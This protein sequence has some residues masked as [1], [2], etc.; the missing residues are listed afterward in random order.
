MRRII[1]ND[2]LTLASRLFVGGALIY[3]SYY[4]II[5]PAT[6][7]KSIWYYHMVPGYLINLMALILPWLEM[8]C[9]LALILGIWYRGAVLWSNALLL[10][11]IVALA[12]TIARGLS[13]DC[14]CFKAGK[15]AT[16]PAWDAL[17]FDVVAIVFALQ[18]WFSRS[19]KWMLSSSRSN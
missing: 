7:A 15:S 19:R 6:F 16:A 10:I 8:L 1:D 11:F 13:I 4:K 9:G 12:S 5:E 2:L 18:M 3:A 17:W 14:G